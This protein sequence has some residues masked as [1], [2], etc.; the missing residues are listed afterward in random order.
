MTKQYISKESAV[1]CIDA[2]ISMAE[3]YVDSL[4]NI[5]QL[6]KMSL[7]VEVDMEKNYEADKSDSKEEAD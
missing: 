7:T 3:S 4:R 2:A 1:A 5:R 6:L